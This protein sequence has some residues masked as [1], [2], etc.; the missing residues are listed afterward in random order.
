MNAETILYLFRA[1]RTGRSHN[2][3]D[4]C[5]LSL[6]IERLKKNEVIDC[7]PALWTEFM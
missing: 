4:E 2:G 7:M 6:Y 5:M 1:G 3:L